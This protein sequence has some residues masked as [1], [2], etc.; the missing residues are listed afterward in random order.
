L[1]AKST[2]NQQEKNAA[3]TTAALPASTEKFFLANFSSHKKAEAIHH[4]S[5]SFFSDAK[6][7]HKS[8]ILDYICQI[9]IYV[10]IPRYTQG[11]RVRK[12]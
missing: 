8:A 5:M 9:Y 6:Q 2:K 1:L 3:Q 11:R 10:Y 12:K 7:I 4:L